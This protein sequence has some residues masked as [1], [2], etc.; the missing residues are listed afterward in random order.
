[1][2]SDHHP[3]GGLLGREAGAHWE[4][5]TDPLRARHDVRLDP[6][7][8]V[9]PQ[10][11]GPRDSALDLVEHQHQ[12]VLVGALAKA[13]DE[14]LAC[15]ADSTLAL[16][17]LDQEARRILVDRGQRRFE[18][19]ELDDLEARQERREPVAQL[20]LVGGADRRHRP[21]VERVGESD[22]VVLVRI[23]LGVMIA[24]RRLDRALDRFRARIGEEHR[25]GE[26]IVDQPLRESLALR[27]PVQV[28]HMHQ[29]RRLLL[30]RLGQ[31]RMA[32]AEQVDRDPGREV[33]IFLAILAVE[34]D[35]LSPHGPHFA[36]RVNG[37]ER[38]DGHRNGL[39]LGLAGL[40]FAVAI[41]RAASKVKGAPDFSSAPSFAFSDEA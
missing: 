10:S 24:P 13:L 5:A 4:S 38:R 21:P 14:L 6:V 8:L 18:I 17:R 15:R 34:I 2:G 19:V 40:G 22:Q 35:P 7:L 30:D 27:R 20:L 28:R 16:H 41:T 9:G 33:E 37:H 3:A 23:A 12:V 36:T 31:M 39:L 1:M 32:M 25:I 11:P 26:A 29:C